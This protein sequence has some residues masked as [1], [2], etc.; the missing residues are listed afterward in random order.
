MIAAIPLPRLDDGFRV[1]L[2]VLRERA[3]DVRLFIEATLIVA[4]HEAFV[5]TGI[6]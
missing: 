5:S 6:D 3:P 2:P 4:P 1:L